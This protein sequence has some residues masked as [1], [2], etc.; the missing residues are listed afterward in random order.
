MLLDMILTNFT[1]TSIAMRSKLSIWLY[2]YL[3]PL[4]YYGS[5]ELNAQSSVA[6]YKELQKFNFLGKV[7]YVAAHPD[8]ENT[9]VI[10]YFSNF[11]NAETAYISLTR[12]G[13]GQNLIG[14]ELRDELGLIRTYELIEARK[15]DGGKQFFS[16]AID[17]GYSKSS[18]ETF[19]LWGKNTLLNQTLDVIHHFR[20]DIII[21]RFD[22]NRGRTHGHHTASAM[23]SVEAFDILNNDSLG[24]YK[25]YWKP[26]RL[27]HN[28]SWWFYGSRENFENAMGQKNV[29]SLEVGLHDPISGLTNSEIAALSRSQ[30]K[31]Q[32]FGSSPHY[33]PR[34]EYLELI[35]GDA[36]VHDVFDGIDTSW[37]RIEGGAP[38]AQWMKRIIDQYDFKAPYK[39]VPDL[40][41]VYHL[42]LEL[43][44]EELV[45]EKSSK[46]KSIIKAAIGLELQYN[47]SKPFGIPREQ[48]HVE[49]NATNLGPLSI[50][51][52]SIDF[53]ETKLNINQPLEKHNSYN[54]HNHIT[55][56]DFLTT[57]FWLLEKKE[58][59]NY[60]VEDQSIQ[61]LPDTPEKIN[62]VFSFEINDTTIE[63]VESLKYRTNDPVKGE[64]VAL[65]QVV[66]HATFGFDQSSYLFNN[67]EPHH[68][69]VQ[70]TSHGPNFEGNLSINTPDDWLIT[71]ESYKVSLDQSGQTNNFSFLVEPPE[72][73]KS[74][75]FEAIIHTS[76]GKKLNHQMTV[77][78]YPH[79]SRHYKVHPSV[80]KAT[81]LDFKTAVKTIGY[82]N[83][84]GDEIP[85][86]LRSVGI[87]VDQLDIDQIELSDIEKYET[88]VIGIRAFN[89]KESM[90]Q[91]SKIL[92]KYA[93]NG[94]TLLI[95][96]NTSRNLQ[97][98]QITPQNLQLSRLRVTDENSPVGFI[99]ES[100]PV[101][102]HPNKIT[103]SDFDHWIQ[104]RG[105]YFAST[106]D[107]SFQPI[108]TMNDPGEQP[109]EGSL[110]IADH[111]RGKIIYTGIS[112][113]R[114]LPYGV[115][116][117]YRLF[118]NLISLG[119]EK[120]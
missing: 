35:R 84:A 62:A 79:I 16:T 40:L 106:W 12:G 26:K 102:N 97:V 34:T 46:L 119:H 22:H 47:T 39:S 9:A 96:Y 83:G 91:K 93:E 43:E 115:A 4:V 110:L 23:L 10:S 100:H 13:G 78:D 75:D 55:L 66:P 6:I 17:F 105:L 81:H 32:G 69:H 64:V 118:A 111:H 56:E 120:K 98:S 50:K 51:L 27:F 49:L 42:V 92:W 36:P 117:A 31:S 65:F 108:L 99:D 24:I 88:L 68:V 94:G 76:N 25:D 15:I 114:L 54:S 57:P 107:K 29:L 103:K 14:P 2:V 53:G 70:V 95:Q 38:I 101:L 41:K 71:P 90:A 77:I 59:N 89:V 20:P 86:S 33:G 21:N 82:V 30:H 61:Y 104:E 112:F 19:S 7:L 44:D 52:N 45:S 28:T 58:K 109:L 63:F 67:H 37:N 116:G 87:Q 18:E 11:R 60:S 1:L 5:N 85:S 113:F 3:M 48:L 80:T 74:D 73:F 8:D 72:A